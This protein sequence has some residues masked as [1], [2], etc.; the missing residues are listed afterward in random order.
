M[1]GMYA[2]R[3]QHAAFAGLFAL[4][5]WLTSFGPALPFFA[6]Q[7]DV[8]LGTAGLLVTALASGS[9]TASLVVSLRLGGAEPVRL[10]TLGLSLAAAASGLLGAAPSLPLAVAA[11]LALGVGDGL[12]VASGHA[13][14]ART[15]TDLAGEMNRLNIYFAGGAVAGPLYSGAVLEA[16]GS[17]ELTYAGLSAFIACAALFAVRTPNVGGGEGAHHGPVVLRP[18]VAAMAL[19][20]FLYVGAE[21]GLGA[22]LASYAED[23]AEAGVLAGAAITS[24]YWGAMGASRI[25]AQHLLVR[26]DP[27]T[28]LVAFIVLSG[29]GSALL[30]A[31]GSVLAVA[32]AAAFLTGIGFG[33]VWPLVMGV[34]LPNT[35]PS[36]SAA[37]VTAGNSGAIVFPFAQGAVL[38]GAGATEGVAVTALLCGLML[39]VTAAAYRTG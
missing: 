4:G 21:I 11:T 18:I 39:A 22:W 17:L 29:M 19:V 23:A 10:I 31:T 2:P 37:M 12:V 34:A 32:F 3:P 6:R 20:L 9:V 28:L 27:R 35:T 30:V 14:V 1:G 24:G 25:A 26:H 5:V 36:T 38:A 8:G 7:T 16:T 33:P 15:A 13:L